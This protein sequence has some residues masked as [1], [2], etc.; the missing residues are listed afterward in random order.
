MHRWVIACVVVAVTVAGCGDSSSTGTQTTSASAS[1]I[2]AATRFLNRYVT[3]D[4]RVIRHDQGGD[5]VSEGQA[6]GML[7]AE[8]ANRP[9]L[10]AHIWRWTEQ[11]LLRTDGLLSFHADG[12]GRVFDTDSAT[13]A[14]VLAA[15]A[16]LRYRGPAADALHRTGRRLANAVL[17]VESVTVAGAP[18]LVAGPWARSSTPPVVNPSYWMPSV[19]ASIA[20]YTGDDR[21]SAAASE[22]THLLAALTNGGTTLPPDWATLRDGQLA[23]TGAPDGSAPVQYGLDAARLP[24]WLAAGCRPRARDLA[25]A[26]WRHV[27]GR[28]D[29]AAFLAVTLDGDPLNRD[30][31]PVPLLAGAAA[32]DA[33]GDERAAVELRRRG[34]DQAQI[35]PTY[36]G[37]AW[38][39][40]AGALADGSLGSCAEGR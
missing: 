9:A 13:D 26:W 1:T 23:A 37:D 5:I 25:A 24:L 40:L 28:S 6:Y 31:N 10:A 3:R 20:Q 22:A 19:F 35:T 39:A 16:L 7:I 12:T 36:Y 2:A 32:A 15:Y 29:R 21:W 30:T 27:L 33:A 38:L 14:D 8:V 17:D 11:H 18:V 4:G 34:A